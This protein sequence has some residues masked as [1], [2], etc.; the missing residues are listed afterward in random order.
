[1]ANL[2]CHEY[3]MRTV[4]MQ[5][6]SGE[7][8]GIVRT[9]GVDFAQGFGI[10]HPRLLDSARGSRPMKALGERDRVPSHQADTRG[11]R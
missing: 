8:L 7:I 11:H 4:C 10:E 3:G 9:I 5:V 6:E 2:R 1:M